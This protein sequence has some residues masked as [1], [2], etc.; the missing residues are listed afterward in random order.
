M[1]FNVVWSIW[2]YRNEV[3]FN[4][5]VFDLAALMCALKIKLGQWVFYYYPKFPYNSSVVAFNLN[6]VWDW[7]TVAFGRS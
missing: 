1:F 4:N 3:K 7:S 2:Y 6:A 5:K